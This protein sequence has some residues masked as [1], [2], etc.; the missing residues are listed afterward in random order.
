MF[1]VSVSF[2]FRVCV[3]VSVG[4]N[5]RVRFMVNFLLALGFKLA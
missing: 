5:F 3:R 4:D 2:G 1:K